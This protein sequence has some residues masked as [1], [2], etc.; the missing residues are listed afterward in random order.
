MI[1]KEEN[2][3]QSA[4]K[5]FAEKGYK[6]ASTREIAKLAGVNISMIAYYFGSKEKLFESIFSFKMKKSHDFIEKIMDNDELDEWQKITTMVESYVDKVQENKY[7]YRIIQTEQLTNENEGIAKMMMESKLVFL[8]IYQKL[9]DDGL[10]KN[11]FTKKINVACMHATVSGTIFQSTNNAAFYK[12]FMDYADGANYET[13]FSKDI[14]IHLKI[15][16]KDLLG[17]EK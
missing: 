14:K 1:S 5:I 12:K 2:I 17:Y 10:A 8:K 3:L 15:I 13:E 16:L 6:G 9:M 11:I 4:E 7:F